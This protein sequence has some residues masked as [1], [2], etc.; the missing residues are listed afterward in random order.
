MI[1]RVALGGQGSCLAAPELSGNN[2]QVEGQV[3]RLKLLKRQMY[4]RAKSICFGQRCSYPLTFSRTL[5]KT[6]MP[7]PNLHSA[8]TAAP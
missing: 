7:G 8:W 6:S 2:G 3:D 1:L 4:E 5:G